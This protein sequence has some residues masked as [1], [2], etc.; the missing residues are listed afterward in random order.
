M[1]CEHLKRKTVLTPHLPHYGKDVC[2]DC[3][4]FLGWLKKPE[5]IERDKELEKKISELKDAEDD[6]LLSDWESNFIESVGNQF[7]DLSPKQREI[8][9]RIHDDLDSRKYTWE[10]ICACEDENLTSWESDFI[11]S[12]S[13]HFPNLSEKQT[14]ILDKICDKYGI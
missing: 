14:E 10:R 11:S 5:T 13:N 2:E 12:I 9:K 4:Q 8:I 3:N 1:N 7:P 6:L